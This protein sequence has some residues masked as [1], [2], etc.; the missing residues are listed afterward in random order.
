M[1]FAQALPAINAT[2]NATTGILLL[3]AYALEKGK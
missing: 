2:L 1:T 3:I